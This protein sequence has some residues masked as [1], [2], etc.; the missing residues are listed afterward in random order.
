MLGL[1]GVGPAHFPS[2][3]V[4]TL[5]PNGTIATEGTYTYFYK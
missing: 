4:Y 1:F 2:N 5:N 3:G